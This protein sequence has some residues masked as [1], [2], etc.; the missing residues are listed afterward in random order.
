MGTARMR[1]QY[2]CRSAIAFT[3]ARSCSRVRSASLILIGSGVNSSM[4]G[5]SDLPFQYFWMSSLVNAATC[6]TNL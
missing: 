4:N 5:V 6:I 1:R 3:R 2:W